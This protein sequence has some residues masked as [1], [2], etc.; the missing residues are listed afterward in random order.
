MPITPEGENTGMNA[1]DDQLNGSN[2]GSGGANNEDSAAPVFNEVG[3][4]A[5]AEPRDN[6][7]LT[8]N[9][10]GRIDRE[11]PAGTTESDVV[12]EFKITSNVAGASIMVDGENS[13]KTTN[14]ILYLKLSDVLSTSGKTITLIKNGY[15]SPQR[16]E[17]QAFEN[18][19]FA[20]TDIGKRDISGGYAYTSTTPYVLIVRKFLRL[21]NHLFSLYSKLSHTFYFYTSL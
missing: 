13:Y 4:G 1:S 20:G 2:R 6:T 12:Y 17:I 11:A 5:G 19:K 18:P 15:K 10:G 9:N 16:F 21:L 14:D 8:L 7:R 3:G